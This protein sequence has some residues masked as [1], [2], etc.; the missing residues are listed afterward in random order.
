VVDAGRTEFGVDIQV[1]E[2]AS[3]YWMVCDSGKLPLPTGQGLKDQDK[4]AYKTSNPI[5]GSYS[6][7]TFDLKAFI[8]VNGLRTGRTY[9]L[10]I[11]AE[12]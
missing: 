8:S 7:A 12:D 5:F 3:V 9:N 4:S 11:S 2:P 6:T 10:Y 1:N